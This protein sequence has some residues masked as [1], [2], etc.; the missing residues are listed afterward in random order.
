MAFKE[1]Q[2]K[3]LQLLHLSQTDPLTQL[4]N[5]GT[6]EA[7][8]NECLELN[9]RNANTVCVYFIDLDNF[10]DYNDGHGHPQGDK[11]IQLQAQFLK[12]IFQRSTDIVARFG[13]EEFVVVTSNIDYAQ[14]KDFAQ[15]I[16][17]K[18]SLTK[19]KHAKGKGAEFVGCSVGYYY[20]TA[21][22]NTTITDLIKK[23]D[24]A[25]YRA[26]N[27]GRACAVLY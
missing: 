10:K 3:T 18:W 8:F 7:R 24:D 9:K 16:I 22:V 13:G 25:L 4:L 6:Y 26:K 19:V 1:N 5:R 11:V 27:N 21:N 12:E 23:A 17:D 15:Q 20:E 14:S 2:E